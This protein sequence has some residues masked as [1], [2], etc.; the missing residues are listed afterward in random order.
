[1]ETRTIKENIATITNDVKN[2][3]DDIR[4]IKTN[5]KTTNGNVARCINDINIHNERIK[6]IGKRAQQADE[7]ACKAER[8]SASYF[9][10]IVS[11]VLGNLLCYATIIGLLMIK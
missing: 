6:A 11:I 9:K 7:T 5:I 8:T 10:W 4:E 1:V 2:I 3:K